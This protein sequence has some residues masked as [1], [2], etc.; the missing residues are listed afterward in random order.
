MPG[1]Y[2][3]DKLFGYSANRGAPYIAL[4]L[5]TNGHDGL[6]ESLGHNA[7]FASIGSAVAAGVIGASGTFVSQRAVFVLC[8][9]LTLPVVFALTRM[10][11]AD[12]VPVDPKT[13]HAAQ[14]P[15]AERGKRCDRPSQVFRDKGL[16][17]F[18]A[19]VALF[20]LGSAAVLPI[21][22]N[23]LTKMN[24]DAIGLWLSASIIV[25]QIV[26]SVA[27]ARGRPRRRSPGP[28]SRAPA[29][30]HRTADPGPTLREHA[31]SLC[32]P[33]VSAK[34]SEDNVGRVLT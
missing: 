2:R 28:A 34:P 5:A 16:L 27:L 12:H 30:V 22:V 18:A 6:G 31:G 14:L 21:A 29:R 4:T 7:R 15:P 25:P 32:P 24:G 11:P 23:E 8:A 10:G 9:A 13:G 3:F 33:P 20:L 1:C 17:G 19:S 26:A